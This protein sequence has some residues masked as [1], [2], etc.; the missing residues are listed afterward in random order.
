[1]A[2]TLGN[3]YIEDFS[4]LEIKASQLNLGGTVFDADDLPLGTGTQTIQGAKTFDTTPILGTGTTI[5][6]ASTTATLSSH[7]ATIT[8][9]AAVIT[10][11]ALTTAAGDSQAF[12]ITKTGVVAGDLAFVQDIGGTNTVYA[13]QYKAVCTTD[14][15]TVTVYNSGPTDPLDGT[16]KFNLLVLHA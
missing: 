6:L 14:T 13:Y 5:D 1:M 10:T 2:T 12:V 3:S 16:L 11:E 8:Q 15:I 4:G 9:Y 7:A